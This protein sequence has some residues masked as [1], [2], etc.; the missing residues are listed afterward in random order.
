M[1]VLLCTPADSISK[2]TPSLPVG[3]GTIAG[4]LIKEGHEVEIYDSFLYHSTLK[5]VLNKINSYDPDIVG[6]TCHVEE[7]LEAIELCNAV[8]KEFSNKTVI[9]GGQFAT[10][11]DIEILE[12]TKV[13]IIVRGEGEYT[14]LDIANKKP[15]KDI[16]GIS[17][18][19][20]GKI[21]RN[22]D[23]GFISDLNKI[24][25]IPFELFDYNLY[26]NLLKVEKLSLD[27]SNFPKK[28][29]GLLFG[30]GCPYN[31]IFCSSKEFWKRGY[32]IISPENA[33]NKVKWFTEKGINGF[34]IF[35][36][37]LLLNKK[38]FMKFTDLIKKEKLD[39]KYKC[40]TRADSIDEER[41]RALKQSGCLSV[42]LGIESG[43]QRVLGLMNK[44]L[45]VSDNENAIKKLYEHSIQVKGGVLFNTP[46]ETKA[47]I[48]ESL[49]W[50]IKMNKLY[51]LKT[52]YTTLK[53]YPN[54]DLEKVA[55][56]K[57]KLVNFKWTKPYFSRKNIL[58][59]LNTTIPL[60]ENLPLNTVNRVITKELV[61]NF[62][63]RFVAIYIKR[64]LEYYS[65]FVKPMKSV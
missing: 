46:G 57:G 2:R 45:K 37:H 51:K 36:D 7:R 49:R 20:E 1:K 55:I 54:T 53:I 24:N 6:I 16:D 23:R 8:K 41:V 3:L 25:D 28:S 17:F 30:R 58:F 56:E 9:M 4:L 10:A 26:P 19:K 5:D 48:V 64:K 11:C 50:I 59:S 52:G 15:L 65:S 34:S 43:S 29:A 12:N 35:D 33:V 14:L 27:Q 40:V 13:D 39:I 32:R 44:S 18:R 62:Q 38:W 60:Y 47:D 22:K 21:I 42:T 61:K 63:P 31:C